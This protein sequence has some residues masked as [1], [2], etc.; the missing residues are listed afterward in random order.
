MKASPSG[1]EIML[2]DALPV[3]GKDLCECV[4]CV[5][6]CTLNGDSLFCLVPEM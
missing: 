2:T 4:V 5:C 6:V 3:G 1:S